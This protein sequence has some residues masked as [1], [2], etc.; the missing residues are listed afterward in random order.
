[1]HV[2]TSLDEIFDFVIVGSGGG[3]MCA[4]LFM[5][6]QGKEP[7]ILEKSDKVGGTTAR[8][9]GVMWIPNNRFMKRDGVE[10]SY[11]KALRYLEATAGQSQDAPGSTPERRAAY[12]SEGPKMIDFLVDHGI[13]LTRVAYWPDYYDERDGGSEQGRTVVAELFDKNQL[14]KEW[15][16][17]LE[18]SFL[19]IPARMTESFTLATFNRSWAGKKMLAKVMLR[20]LVAKLTG[21]NWVT[22]GNALQGRMLQAALKA[23]VD[24]RAGCGVTDFITD[25]TGAVTGV[26]TLKDGKPWR[27]GARSGVLVNA[28]GFSHNQA[29]RDKYQPGTSKEW[30]GVPRGNTGEM[31]QKMEALGAQLA[32]ME[33]MVGNQMVIPPGRG[34]HGDGVALAGISGQMDI[35]K[36]HSIVV[37]RSGVRYMNEGGSYME[38]CQNILK[39]NREVP[40]IPSHWI[41]DSQWMNSFMLAGTMAGPK[42][43]AE[44]FESGFLKKADTI[45][46]LAAMIDVAPATLKATIDRWNADVRAGSDT[47]FHR[48]ERAYDRFLGDTVR[49]GKAQ[50]LGTIEKAP[51]YAMPVVPGDVGTYGGVV[52]D[53]HARVLRSDGSV[54]EG[55]YA[56]GIS[57]ASVMG[58]Y[59][60]G[61]GSSIGPSFTWGYVAAKHASGA[62]N[63]AG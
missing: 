52:T 56:T 38:F 24:I 11:D 32:Q 17:K 28:G 26:V 16:S 29:M 34:N 31:I 54:I 10:D 12:V 6:A 50:A 13:E 53:A 49:D 18:P 9:G 5:K 20:G 36:P 43:P 15:R 59:Y 63:S 1:M 39:R 61:A 47:Q 60:P 7:V 33:E 37:D 51:F 3:S 42:K 48:G 22:A 30:T 45:E 40:A 57:T 14:P 46:E 58:R 55:L 35:A 19:N 4:A 41:I 23:Q 2:V 62:G 44:W 8:S 25:E 27:I 21:K